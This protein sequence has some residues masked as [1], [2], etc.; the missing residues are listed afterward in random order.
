[1]SE[2]VTQVDQ[3]IKNLFDGDVVTVVQ[4]ASIDPKVAAFMGEDPDNKVV[5]N[6]EALLKQI[7]SYLGAAADEKEPRALVL[8]RNVLRLRTYSL[9][10]NNPESLKQLGFWKDRALTLEIQL[11]DSYK[12]INELVSDMMKLKVGS[13]AIG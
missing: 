5:D 13:S 4:R 10:Q 8:Y 11:Q 2:T 3:F 6:L 7:Y 12:R 1:M 9:I